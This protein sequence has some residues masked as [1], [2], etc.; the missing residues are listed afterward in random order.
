MDIWHLGDSA[1]SGTSIEFILE[2]LVSQ[3]YNGEGRRGLEVWGTSG[4]FG[5][6]LPPS[7]LHSF[8]NIHRAPAGNQVG[9][10]LAMNVMPSINI[11][12]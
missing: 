3:D 12:A 6:P 10:E 7:L 2:D 11:S 1:G 8:K 9:W 5:G 4:L